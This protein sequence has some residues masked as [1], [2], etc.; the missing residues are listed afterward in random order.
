MK[1]NIKLLLT[2][3]IMLAMSSCATYVD[4]EAE[5]VS[6]TQ[7][8]IEVVVQYGTPYYYRGHV[9]YHYRGYWYYPDPRSHYGYYRYKRQ[10]RPHRYQHESRVEHHPHR[11]DP[12]HGRPGGQA[13]PDNNRP[14]RPHGTPAPNRNGRPSTPRRR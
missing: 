8:P 7:P 6:T 5:V 11:P 14:T 4:P 2:G 13:R 3:L 10:F 12:G 9:Y 1:K